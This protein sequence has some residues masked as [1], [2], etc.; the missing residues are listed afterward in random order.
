[1]K[2]IIIKHNGIKFEGYL[3]EDL[4]TKFRALNETKMVEWHYP[5]ASYS[6]KI[7]EGK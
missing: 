1:M 2:K 3:I 7:V 4:P 5:K 6:Y